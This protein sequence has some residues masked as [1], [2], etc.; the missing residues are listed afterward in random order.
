MITQVI[1]ECPDLPEGRAFSLEHANRLLKVQ[2]KSPNGWKLKEGQ[3][4]DIDE[5]G[6]II[7]ASNR[8]NKKQSQQGSGNESDSPRGEGEVS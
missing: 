1:L 8:V 7:R 6:V 3:K 2:G 4:F 5:N